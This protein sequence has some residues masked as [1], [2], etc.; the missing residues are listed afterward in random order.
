MRLNHWKFYMKAKC[1]VPV[2]FY[3]VFKC[4]YCAKISIGGFNVKLELSKE[5]SI[6]KANVSSGKIYYLA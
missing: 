6:T 2:Y 3:E 4:M 5:N 1:I